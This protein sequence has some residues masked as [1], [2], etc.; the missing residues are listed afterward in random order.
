MSRRRSHTQNNKQK[1]I[2]PALVERIETQLI[3]KKQLEI[4]NKL[5][6]RLVL[7]SA[8]AGFVNAEQLFRS[9]SE[10]FERIYIGFDQ[11]I[12]NKLEALADLVE[13]SQTN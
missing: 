8:N 2:D 13:M 4:T 7:S 10:N 9:Y 6:N 5:L 11:S 1:K 3:F 12:D